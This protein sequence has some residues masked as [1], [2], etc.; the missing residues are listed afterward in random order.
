M[1]NERVESS[2]T[3]N[4]LFSPLRPLF[5]LSKIMEYW[6]E[7]IAR[8][9]VAQHMRRECVRTFLEYSFFVAWIGCFFEASRGNYHHFIRL[10]NA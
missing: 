6:H 8:S 1:K 4:L 2:A 10:S 9:D 3:R 7:Y 5:D